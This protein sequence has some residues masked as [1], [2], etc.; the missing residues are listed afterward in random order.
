[1]ITAVAEQ[2]CD[3]RMLMMVQESLRWL[4]KERMSTQSR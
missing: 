1:M 4:F 3:Y 2:M